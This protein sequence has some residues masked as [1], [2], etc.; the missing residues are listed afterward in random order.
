MR[1]LPESHPVAAAVYFLAASGVAMFCMDPVLLALSLLGALLCQGLHGEWRAWRMHL[2][3][4]LLFCGMALVNPIVSHNGRTVLFVVNDTLITLESL[5]YGVASAAMVTSVLYWFRT[6]AAI[7]TSDK[8]LCL[9]GALS[10]KMS[11]ILSMAMRYV[12][13]FG[14]QVQKVRQSQKA[15]GLYREDNL[16]DAFRGGTRVFSVMVT[17]ALENGVTTA[18]SM[19][20]R[21]YG[22]G[23]RSR[24]SPFLWTAGDGVLIG[25]SLLLAG[26]A[27]FAAHARNFT[28]YPGVTCAPLT[29]EILLGY[30]SYGLLM[31]LPAIL[32]GKEA[33]KWHCLRSKT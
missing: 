3:S 8:L 28:F 27:A 25:L 26:A 24:Y 32:K 29:A 11:L 1:T 22:I 30:A 19:V 6:F 7:M 23:K 13:L 15:L 9:F 16:I 18:D 14:Q 5:L 12:P 10:P 33:L 17:W 20:A 21:G 2:F 31:L 4:A